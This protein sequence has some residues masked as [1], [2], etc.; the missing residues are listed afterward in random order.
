MVLPLIP[1]AIGLAAEFAPQLV[2]WIAGEKAGETAQEVIE[3]AHRVT[4]HDTLDGA[5]AALRGS[6]ELVA[7]LRSEAAAL[8][9]ELEKAHLADRADARARDVAVQ[10]QRGRNARADVLA[11]AAIAGL[12]GLIWL[13]VFV[14]IPAGPARDVLL[15]L[16]GALIAVV[17]DVYGFEFGSSRGSKDKDELA[18]RRP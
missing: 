8:A 10:Q 2:R 6:P 14:E 3:L 7:R 4:G 16:A 5:A 11:F 12:I 17:K 18:A 1:A 9:A 13:V 15:L